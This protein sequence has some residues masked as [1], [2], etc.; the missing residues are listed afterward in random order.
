MV[1]TRNQPVATDTLDVSQPIL[2]SN[3]NGADDSFGVDHYLFS[4][5]T[6][7][8]GFH[9]TVTTPAIIGGV[10]PTTTAILDKFYALQ[11]TV[12]LGLL[13]YSRGYDSANSVSAVPT[14]VTNIYSPATPLTIAPAATIPILDFAGLS[15]AMATLYSY[16]SILGFI[17]TADIFWNGVAFSVIQS[18]TNL[19]QISAAGSV[20]LLKNSDIFPVTYNNVYWSLILHR[21]Q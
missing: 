3:T 9:N 13:Q 21:V 4:D 12:P 10:D 6:A 11:R 18:S 5:L 19:F 15:I 1:Y 16:D 17:Q 14:P 8:N 7:N 2:L 20:L